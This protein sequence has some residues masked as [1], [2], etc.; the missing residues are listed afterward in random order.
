MKGEVRRRPG[1][2]SSETAARV[3]AATLALLAEQGYERLQLPE[4]AV[5]A[6]VNKSTVYRRWPSK[7]QLVAELLGAMADERVPN[8]DTGALV[9]DLE[10][11]LSR[12]ADVLRT[13][14]VRAVIRAVI[15]L[16]EDDPEADS[17]R[18]TFWARQFDDAAPVIERA[19]ARGEL[20][21][22]TDHRAFLERA[23]GPLYFRILIT[24]SDVGPDDLRE[25]AG[26]RQSG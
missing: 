24:G 3:R 2:R 7:P 19:I 1:G 10:L 6:G 22:G 17:V 11:M 16:A 4:V 5:R 18:R 20:P 26:I 14:A 25:L 12:V 13:P 9:T 8:P 21:T 15:T 23:F